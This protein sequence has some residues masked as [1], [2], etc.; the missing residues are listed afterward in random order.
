MT[1]SSIE[2]VIHSKRKAAHLEKKCVSTYDTAACQ[3]CLLTPFIYSLLT[4]TLTKDP[5]SH[6]FSPA[7]VGGNSDAPS[8]VTE[9]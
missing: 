1:Q 6:L 9:L 5:L 8:K 2:Q 4:H 7:Q 3:T